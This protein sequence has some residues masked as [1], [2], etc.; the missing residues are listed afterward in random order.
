[1]TQNQLNVLSDSRHFI[2]TSPFNFF[3]QFIASLLYS[4]RTCSEPR[5]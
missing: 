1:M 2:L 4:Y 5:K 3:L